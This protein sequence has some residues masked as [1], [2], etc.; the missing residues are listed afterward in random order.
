ML[1]IRSQQILHMPR[2]HRIWIVNDTGPWHRFR[3]WFLSS[4]LKSCENVF[5]LILFLMIWLRPHFAHVVV[6]CAKWWPDVIHNPQISATWFFCT[7]NYEIIVQWIWTCKKISISIWFG[8]HTY[9]QSGV[10][11]PYYHDTQCTCGG[12]GG[13]GGG[14]AYDWHIHIY[15]YSS[16][17]VPGEQTLKNID[18]CESIHMLNVYQSTVINKMKH[19]K[20]PRIFTCICH[21]C[22]WLIFSRLSP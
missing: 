10:S 16:E 15:L 12:G 4:S 7:S 8:N 18:N 1:A 9:I 19:S 13:G 17:F 14:G 5:I 22:T 6:I 11:F 2:Q 21:T 3:K 20:Y